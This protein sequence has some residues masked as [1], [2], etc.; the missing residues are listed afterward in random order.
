MKDNSEHGVFMDGS[1]LA[2]ELREID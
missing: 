2:Q 1:N